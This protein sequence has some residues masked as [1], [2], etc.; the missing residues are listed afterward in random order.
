[1]P[2][3]IGVH[4]ASD[5]GVQSSKAAT[6][7]MAQV[8]KELGVPSSIIS[9]MMV[10]PHDEVFWLSPADLKSMGTKVAAPGQSDKPR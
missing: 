1:V 4:G 7:A 9:R 3:F 10:T 5:K 6:V 2:A 8:A